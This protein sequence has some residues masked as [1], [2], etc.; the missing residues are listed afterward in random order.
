[1]DATE[2]QAPEAAPST[3]REDARERLRLR[4]DVVNHLV[5]FL[6]VNGCFVAI[7]VMTGG[8]YFW[9]A[10][11]L[12]TWAIGLLLHAWDVFVRRPISEADVDAEVRRTRGVR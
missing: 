10:W 1:M 7:W 12:G 2:L 3:T 6:V 4:R 9:P 5:A 11:V 8:G